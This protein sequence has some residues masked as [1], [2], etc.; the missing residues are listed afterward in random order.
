[1]LTQSDTVSCFELFTT[2][3]ASETFIYK[4]TSIPR[5]SADL[6]LSSP[7]PLRRHISRLG[8][9]SDSRYRSDF[10]TRIDVFRWVLNAVSRLSDVSKLH[11][12]RSTVQVWNKYFT[13]FRKIYE[14]NDTTIIYQNHSVIPRL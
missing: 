4:N 2:S 1:M 10:L 14:E 8:L 12:D 9:R 13:M 3:G 7:W 5:L 6:C 11:S